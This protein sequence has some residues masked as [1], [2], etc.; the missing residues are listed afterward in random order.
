HLLDRL[1]VKAGDTPLV[2][3]RDDVALRN[4]SIAQLAGTLGYNDAIDQTHLRDLVIVGAGPAGLA[5]AVYGASEGLD[6]LIVEA[7]APGGQAGQSSSIENYLGFP[8]GVSGLDLAA[9]ATSQAV[10]FGAQIMVAKNAR[11]LTCARK[12]Y[13]VQIDDDARVAART[14]IIA[15]GAQYRRPAVENLSRFEN[16]GVYYGATF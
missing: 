10:K 7:D 2:I 3:Y 11:G 5:A 8:T 16:A 1:H 15:T 6:V 13:A 14:V 12:P 4:P 9:R